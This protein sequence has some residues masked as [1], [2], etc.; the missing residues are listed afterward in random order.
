MLATMRR[1]FTYRGSTTDRDFGSELRVGSGVPP[2]PGSWR[3]RCSRPQR[4]GDDARTSWNRLQ[5]SATQ[6]DKKSVQ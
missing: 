3:Q 1:N 6:P 2:P 5:T 4:P